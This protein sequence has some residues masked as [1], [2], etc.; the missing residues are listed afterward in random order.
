MKKTVKKLALVKETMRNL[1]GRDVYRVVGG[2]R[3]S[4]LC[5]PGDASYYCASVRVVC[6]D[7]TY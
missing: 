1:E 5:N 2:E 3:Y 6:K 7:P 4:F